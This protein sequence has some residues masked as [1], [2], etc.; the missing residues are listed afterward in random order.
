L[1]KLK[2]VMST[3]GF[4]SSHS[5]GLSSP[6]I[7]NQTKAGNAA[8]VK[9]EKN[10]LDTIQTYWA[11]L[12][13]FLGPLRP[14]LITSFELFEPFNDED[15]KSE[16]SVALKMKFRK[17]IISTKWEKQIEELYKEDALKRTDEKT[18]EKPL[19][20]IAMRGIF[21]VRNICD[22]AFFVWTRYC[23]N[24]LANF[25]RN[26][27]VYGQD[28]KLLAQL[29]HEC[30]N[31][32]LVAAL[33]STVAFA[34]FQTTF[35]ANFD[36]QSPYGI[37]FA[38]TWLCGA[39][40]SITSAIASVMILMACEESTGTTET[41]YFVSILNC[42]TLGLGTMFPIVLLYFGVIFIM[43]GIFSGCALYFGIVRALIVF[44][45]ATGVFFLFVLFLLTMVSSLHVTRQ[46]ARLI[47]TG[48]EGFEVFDL[49]V[50]Q[51]RDALAK[52]IH[53]KKS[54]EVGQLQE[55]SIEF[56]DF[57]V[58]TA[59]PEVEHEKII[60]K[61]TGKKRQKKCGD[62]LS[63]LCQAR[64]IKFYESFIHEFK[65]RDVMLSGF[66]VDFY[67]EKENSK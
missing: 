25:T 21:H 36:I 43:L 63:P 59:F 18:G 1:T 44:A 39:V 58:Y 50:S 24:D 55:S 47:A 38:I 13:C 17:L 49:T 19:P 54:D 20:V 12:F 52:F 14:Y 35:D 64:A 45:S 30:T 61:A 62:R 65:I 16:P 67:Y 22:A 3:F 10:F 41:N 2:K 9:D 31:I 46:T 7:S 48:F 28:E 40:L 23:E 4:H 32:G 8:Y 56:L 34:A 11:M 26:D 60:N 5:D 6:L 42:V 27:A 53:E 15:L 51:V 33:I 66:T 37:M 57:I 29:R